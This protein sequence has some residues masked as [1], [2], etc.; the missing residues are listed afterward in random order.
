[1]TT[2]ITRIFSSKRALLEE[3]QENTATKIKACGVV[4]ETCHN[5]GLISYCSRDKV[6]D[7][8][9][10]YNVSYDT[11]NVSEDDMQVLFVCLVIE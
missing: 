7:H 1:M 3:D 9:I 5:Y 4:S 8:K 10:K 2:M 11:D 6:S